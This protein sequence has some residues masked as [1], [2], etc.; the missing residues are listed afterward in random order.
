MR[1]RISPE[2]LTDR[3]WRRKR[4]R[5]DD[6]VPMLDSAWEEMRA[7]NM[8]SYYSPIFPRWR[9][10]Y[11]MSKLQVQLRSTRQF[12]FACG[13]VQHNPVIW[14]DEASCEKC[15]L[16]SPTS[17]SDLSA[18]FRFQAGTEVIDAPATPCNREPRKTASGQRGDGEPPVK[19]DQTVLSSDFTPSLCTL[20]GPDSGEE[21]N[22][23][24]IVHGAKCPPVEGYPHV[25]FACSNRGS[26]LP[27]QNW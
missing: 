8:V 16:L 22:Q 19:L 4:Q 3:N 5:R 20:D 23:D 6:V 18:L 24:K 1:K 25:I 9:S 14:F 12:P 21:T 17:V 11:R 7:T 26:I 27:A 2:E 15:R 10:W 13:F